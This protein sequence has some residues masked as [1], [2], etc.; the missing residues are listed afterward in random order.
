MLDYHRIMATSTTFIS[1]EQNE[2]C[3]ACC[4]FHRRFYTSSGLK[5]HTRVHSEVK[6]FSCIHC[7]KRFSTKQLLRRHLVK[8][9]NDRPYMCPYCK[10][11]YKT[12]SICRK[13]IKRHRNDP[14]LH[15]IDLIQFIIIHLCINA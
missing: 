14:D 5:D 2:K 11:R 15:V 12:I 10:K 13:H 8:H 4:C 7:P 6:N 3:K 1:I 9:S